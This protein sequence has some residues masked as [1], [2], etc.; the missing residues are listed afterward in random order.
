MC[1][2]HLP[3][4]SLSRPTNP[5]WLELPLSWAKS[6]F[7]S[8][9]CFSGFTPLW[10]LTSDEVV[11][12]AELTCMLD[13]NCLRSKR[14][15]LLFLVELCHKNL[16]FVT[17]GGWKSSTRNN[18]C[19]AFVQYSRTERFL[20]KQDGEHK[21]LIQDRVIWLQI[22]FYMFLLFTMLNSYFLLGHY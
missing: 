15:C 7:N 18:N 5:L 12:R 17:L 21:V 16:R 6:W 4:P 3:I 14:C 22:I 13:E 10:A 8:D 11:N 20:G 2:A 1:P 19:I 9:C